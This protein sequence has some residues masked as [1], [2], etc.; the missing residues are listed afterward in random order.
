M[1]IFAED[2]LHDFRFVFA[3]QSVVYKDAGEL[4]ADRFMQKRRRDGRIDPAAQTEHHFFIADLP[5]HALARFLDERAHR[6]IHR[7]MADV[8]DKILED[9]F[10]A[11]RVGNLRM[12][13]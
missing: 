1:K 3:K 6:P 7:A 2:A 4:I 11:R 8:I 13:L 9:H 10:A 12:K 5:S